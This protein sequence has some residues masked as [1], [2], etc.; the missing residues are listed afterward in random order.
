MNKSKKVNSTILLKDGRKLLTYDNGFTYAV[1]SVNGV[2][3]L[4]S[5]EYYKNQMKHRITKKTNSNK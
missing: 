1:E 5:E 3:D 2:I 4:V